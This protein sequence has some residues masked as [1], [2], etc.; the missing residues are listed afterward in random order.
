MRVPTRR[1]EKLNPREPVDLH[2]TPQAVERMKREL[3]RLIKVDRPTIIED[4]QRTAQMGDFSENFGYQHAKA[5]LRRTND[6]ILTLEARIAHAI[7]IDKTK[8][9]GVVRIGSTVTVL[10][11]QK[12]QTFEILGSLESNPFKGKISYRSPLGS[13]LMGGRVGDKV[14]VEAGGK[15]IVYEIAAVE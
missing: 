8:N 3:E 4:V 2:L 11:S 10:T 7:V 15:E 5:Q 14:D 9:D 1:G 13:A 12:A 6:R